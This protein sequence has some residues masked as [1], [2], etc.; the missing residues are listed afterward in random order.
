MF[1]KVVRKN[2]FHWFFDN[3]DSTNEK[4]TIFKDKWE[5]NKVMKNLE[6]KRN[7]SDFAIFLYKG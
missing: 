5:A 3:G 4:P 7:Y 1:L 2:V 6:K